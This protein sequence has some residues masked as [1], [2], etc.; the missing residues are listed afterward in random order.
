MIDL[1]CCSGCG[2][3][4]TIRSEYKIK[5]KKMYCLDCLEEKKQQTMSIIEQFLSSHTDFEKISG[6][7]YTN[8]IEVIDFATLNECIDFLIEKGK[9]IFTSKNGLE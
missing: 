5:N 7:K 2:F 3:I 4:S 9:I 6:T 1:Y 8:G